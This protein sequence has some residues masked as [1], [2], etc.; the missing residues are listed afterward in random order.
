MTEEYRQLNR[1]EK[2]RIEK[3]LQREEQEQGHLKFLTNQLAHELEVLEEKYKWAA[4]AKKKELK[5]Q[6]AQVKQM[7]EENTFTIETMKEQLTKGVLIKQKG[8]N[9]PE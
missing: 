8:E 6:I 3:A 4:F 7:V 5:S 9:N 1:D 2:A